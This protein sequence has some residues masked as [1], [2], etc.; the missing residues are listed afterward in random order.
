MRDRV[1]SVMMKWWLWKD[2]ETT[3]Q[4]QPH[5]V[6]AREERGGKDTAPHN[7]TYGK[8]TTHLTCVV[9]SAHR[10]VTGVFFF[11]K[12][13]PEPFFFSKKMRKFLGSHEKRVKSNDKNDKRVLSI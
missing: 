6:F 9:R 4:C 3:L 5:F 8:F 1:K 10:V 12:L 13:M 2:R 7:R 11:R